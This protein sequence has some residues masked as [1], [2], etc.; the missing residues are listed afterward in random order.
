MLDEAV[1]RVSPHIQL[2]VFN[3]C[4]SRLDEKQIVVSFGHRDISCGAGC[5]RV[6]CW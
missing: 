6:L 5:K 3:P 1:L 2:T 4:P